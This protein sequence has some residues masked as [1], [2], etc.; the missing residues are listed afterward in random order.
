MVIFKKAVSH[1]GEECDVCHMDAD[2]FDDI[3]DELK[4]KAHAVCLHNGKMLLV[5]HLDW[6]IWSI[7]GGTRDSGESIEETLKREIMEEANCEVINYRP[8]SYQG[9]IGPSGEIKHYG[10]QYLC[11]VVPLGDFKKDPAGN[12]SKIA[13]INPSD[14][15][16]YIENKEFK[17]SIIRRAIELLDSHKQ[18]SGGFGD[19][20]RSRL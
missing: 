12:I 3:P 4:L 19:K 17:R 18:G 9:V 2:N 1:N 15:E 20:I 10:L 6:D 14:F 16:G 7:P 5:N 11:D 8:I 13:W